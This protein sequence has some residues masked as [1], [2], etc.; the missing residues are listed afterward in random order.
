MCNSWIVRN[1]HLPETVK[2]IQ[3]Q[4]SDKPS[5]ESVPVKFGWNEAFGEPYWTRGKRKPS[6]DL[7]FRFEIFLLN[8]WPALKTEDKVLHLSVIY[9]EG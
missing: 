1:F 2:S 4:V 7:F 9:Q 5:A 3:I 6:R 8:R